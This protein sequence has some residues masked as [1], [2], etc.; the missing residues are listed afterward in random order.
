MPRTYLEKD[1]QLEKWHNQLDNI[2]KFLNHLFFQLY[3]NGN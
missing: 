2:R 3:R 1:I